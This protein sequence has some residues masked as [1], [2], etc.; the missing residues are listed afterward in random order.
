MH[1]SEGWEGNPASLLMLKK[2]YH[3]LISQLDVVQ[4]ISKNAYERRRT[5][6]EADKEKNIVVP[7]FLR[8]RAIRSIYKQPWWTAEEMRECSVP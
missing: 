4:Q 8:R 2:P 5:D 3:Q 1:L 6:P 7:E